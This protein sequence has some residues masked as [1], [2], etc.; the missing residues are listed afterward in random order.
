M[1]YNICNKIF[2]VLQH[3]LINNL[4]FTK[5]LLDIPTLYEILKTRYKT[6]YSKLK[7]SQIYDK[8]N[9]GRKWKSFIH[10]SYTC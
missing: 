7:I 9:K 8:L 4:I 5:I 2:I 3:S 10:H 6:K 1:D